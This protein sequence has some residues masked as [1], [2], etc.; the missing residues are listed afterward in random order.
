LQIGT[1]ERI[2]PEL[3]L[4]ARVRGAVLWRSGSQIV[5]QLIT[6]AATFIVI[7]LLNPSDYGLFAMTE[8]S[9]SSST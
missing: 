2:D 7:R 8:V 9:S 5:G 4:G 3:G 1:D 6:W